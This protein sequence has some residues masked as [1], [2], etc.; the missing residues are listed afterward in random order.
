MMMAVAMVMMM[1]MMMPLM[2]VRRWFR[3]VVRRPFFFK[4]GSSFRF[5]FFSL[6]RR[7]GR[8]GFWGA[9]GRCVSP[10]NGTSASP[11]CHRMALAPTDDDHPPNRLTCWFFSFFFLFWVSTRCRTVWLSIFDRIR[12]LSCFSR[13]H[14]VWNVFYWVSVGFYL[15]SLGLYSVCT[16]FL[17]VS[18]FPG[19]TASDSSISTGLGALSVG[20]GWFCM[21]KKII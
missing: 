5:C 8:E 20:L 2:T 6:I 4:F 12:V 18:V 7:S 14:W 17:S 1:M 16:F 11:F 21:K 19:S 9:I 15:V 10:P 3:S 13:L